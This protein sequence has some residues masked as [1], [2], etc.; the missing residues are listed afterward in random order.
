MNSPKKVSGI[1]FDMDGTLLDTETLS[2]WAIIQVFKPGLL[3][4]EVVDSRRIPWEL[5]LQTLGL[6]GDAW[7]PLMLNYCRD[8]WKLPPE[9]IPTL[10]EFWEQWESNLSQLAPQVGECPGAA[11]LVQACAA[12]NIPMA[13]ATSSRQAAVDKKR[14]NHE[15]SIFQHLQVIVTADDPAVVNGKPAPDIYLEAARRLNIDPSE[16]LVFED[17]AFGCQS[18]KAAGCQVVAIPD[19]RFTEEQKQELYGPVA[20]VI[21]DS[22]EVFDARPLGL[23]V[24]MMAVETSSS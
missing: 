3:P 8:E 17:A 20:D 14:L 13:I 4:K 23:D 16:C 7:I 2:D 18:G 1:L 9:D 10:E 22:L 11:A 24:N 19:P 6:Q 15:E 12:K 21:V 5:K